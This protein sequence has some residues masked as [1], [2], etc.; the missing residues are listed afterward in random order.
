MYFIVLYLLYFKGT[1]HEPSFV[2]HTEDNTGVTKS[3][4]T[5]SFLFSPLC[6]FFFSCQ[7]HNDIMKVFFV[8]VFLVRLL[9]K[10]LL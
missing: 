6:P 10:V 8:V 1:S 3:D 4:W 2:N 7:F 9:V 5:F